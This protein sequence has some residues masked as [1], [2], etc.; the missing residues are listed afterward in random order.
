[1][2]ILEPILDFSRVKNTF[3]SQKDGKNSFAQFL[4]K[5]FFFLIYMFYARKKNFRAHFEIFWIFGSAAM[6]RNG[7]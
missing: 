3:P 7:K 2:G 6:G 4:N 5:N 1:M